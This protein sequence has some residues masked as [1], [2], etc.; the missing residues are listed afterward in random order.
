[1]SDGW[2][3]D[4]RGN[5]DVLH[6]RRATEWGKVCKGKLGNDMSSSMSD[7]LLEAQAREW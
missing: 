3:D 1:M 7:R 5:E 2:G 6:R 4:L